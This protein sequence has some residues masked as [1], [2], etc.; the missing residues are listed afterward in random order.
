MNRKTT[1]FI[2]ST[3]LLSAMAMQAQ[4][5]SLDFPHFASQEWTM[6]AFHGAEQDTIAS[7]K[8]DA[9]GKATIALPVGYKHYR[10][11][12]RWL[13]KN[14][15]GLDVIFSGIGEDIAV[16]CTEARPSQST[17]IYKGT[18]ENSYLGPRYARQQDILK[19]TSAMRMV[20]KAYED[21]KTLQPVF[22]KELDKQEEAYK[23]LQEETASNPLYAARF[24]QIVDLTQRLPLMLA[25]SITRTDSL[26]TQ[27]IVNSLDISAL[28]TSGHWDEVLGMW[29]QYYVQNPANE[30][31]LADDYQI[32]KD[33]I[34]D[35]EIQTAFVQSVSDL[36]HK[37]KRSDLAL[38]NERRK[39][40][41]L[42]QCKLPNK[43]TI[44]VFHE[45]GCGNCTDQME[46]LVELYPKAKAEGYEVISIAADSDKEIFEHTS[47]AYPWEG[48]YC[49]LKGFAGKDFINYGVIGTPTF[50]LIDEKGTIRGIY[51]QVDDM[52]I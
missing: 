48:K 16:S 30:A 4:S 22:E 33:R 46:K 27:T 14:G 11:M 45:S 20:A 36:L 3:T 8:L 23:L 19:K 31:L 7:G 28:Y 9:S 43:K 32:L 52:K 21:D 49:D 26:L 47:K 42:V 17:I 12:T 24:A 13:L 18:S 34:A 1:L 39:A 15:G 51:A 35:K 25:R 37:M 38:L 6:T 44:L 41:A 29:L 2:I 5:L 40:P 10:G 50:Y